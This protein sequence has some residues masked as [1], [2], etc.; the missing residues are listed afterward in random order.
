MDL[1]L[2][3][4][5]EQEPFVRRHFHNML[6][7]FQEGD[8]LLAHVY[9]IEMANEIAKFK[10]RKPKKARKRRSEMEKQMTSTFEVMTPLKHKCGPT[11]IDHV[12]DCTL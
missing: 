12:E 4:K 7:A 10:S 9:A 11:E 3:T 2:A 1:I 6:E 5:L 8:N